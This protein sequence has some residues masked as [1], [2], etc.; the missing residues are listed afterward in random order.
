[1][2]QILNQLKTYKMLRL[3]VQ[4]VCFSYTPTWW[5]P[6]PFF[7]KSNQTWYPRHINYEKM[8][9]QPTSAAMKSRPA[10][11]KCPLPLILPT[12]KNGTVEPWYKDHLWAATK[13]VLIVRWSLYWG[14]RGCDLG[15]TKIWLGCAKSG[16]YSKVV[17]I[18]RWSLTK[19][20][21]YSSIMLSLWNVI[22]HVPIDPTIHFVI[23]ITSLILSPQFCSFGSFKN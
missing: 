11:K 16:L 13:V 20:W 21:L 7:T 15:C 6:V 8:T 1:M 17:S 23:I 3:K 2:L 4:W 18:S 5:T 9:S 19:V 22:C 14:G 12:V 10:W